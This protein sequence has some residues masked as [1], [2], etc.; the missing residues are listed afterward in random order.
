MENTQPMR[1]GS[2]S[3]KKAGTSGGSIKS[4]QVADTAKRVLGSS[5]KSITATTLTAS[6]KTLTSA[7]LEG[8]RSKAGLVAGALADFQSAGGLVVV[9]NVDYG[10]VYA[11]KIYLVVDGASLKVN[12]TVDG[13][14]FGLVAVE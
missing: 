8:L 10:N 14:D 6:P 12:Q 2:E 4:R 1:T 5:S 9:K 13:L 3:G 7:E 11:V